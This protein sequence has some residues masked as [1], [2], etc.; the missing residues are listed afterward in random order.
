[1]K[2]PQNKLKKVTIDELALMVA[3]GFQDVV[4]DID[5]KMDEKLGLLEKRLVSRI[6]GLENRIDDISLNRVSY[7]NFNALQDR[8]IKVE[9]KLG[10]K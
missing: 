9:H 7:Q 4:R 6:N 1:M 10:I 3:N 8:V 2:K 5:G